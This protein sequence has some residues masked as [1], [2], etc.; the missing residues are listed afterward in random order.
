MLDPLTLRN[1]HSHPTDELEILLDKGKRALKDKVK[2]SDVFSCKNAAVLLQVLTAL[3]KE[4][5]LDIYNDFMM[6]W[7]PTL[8]ENQRAEFLF[9]FP[10][11]QNIENAMWR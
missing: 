3:V 5:R 2:T 1:E 6:T 7:P 4:D 8:E 10:A 9:N 11:Y